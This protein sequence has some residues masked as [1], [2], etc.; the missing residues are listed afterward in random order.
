MPCPACSLPETY[1]SQDA[2]GK[3]PVAADRSESPSRIQPRFLL[4]C[5]PIAAIPS[6]WSGGRR[7]AQDRN[8][9]REDPPFS[10]VPT[11]PAKCPTTGHILRASV[12]SPARANGHDGLILRD[13]HDPVV[14]LELH[15][16]EAPLR[17]GPHR[18]PGAARN[19]PA[20][21][22]SAQ[23]HLRA[24]QRPTEWNPRIKPAAA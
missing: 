11:F 13:G 8:C 19:D 17:D 20:A 23:H 22:L 1:D 24:E 3:P 9:R 12:S 15:R 18:S 2:G 4:H 7:R 6:T 21:V 14:R 16:A 10:K 5:S